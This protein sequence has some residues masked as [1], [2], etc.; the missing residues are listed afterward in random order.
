M[1]VSCARVAPSWRWSWRRRATIS[2]GRK[3]SAMP[4]S[5]TLALTIL[6]DVTDAQIAEAARAAG[7]PE[8]LIE[9]REIAWRFFAE[10]VPPIWRRTDLTKFKSEQI[11]VPLAAQGTTLDWG[12]QQAGQGVVFTTLAAAL[13]DHAELVK[14]YLGTAID[15]LAHKFNA[16]HAALWQ[17]GIFLYVPKN[18]SVELPL[19]ASFTLA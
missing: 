17:D 7:E 11:A 6:A 3:C 19:H 4:A 15:P 9:R 1:V 14:Q 8:W 18:V 13:R 2:S 12:A 16:L 10:S 5:N